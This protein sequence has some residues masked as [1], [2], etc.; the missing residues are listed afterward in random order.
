MPHDTKEWLALQR[1]VHGEFARRLAAI[2]DWDGPTPDTEWNV[3]D[4]VTHVIDEQREVPALLDGQTAEQAR[5]GF[6][7]L[8][9]DLKAEWALYS[10]AA[11]AA[12]HS[13]AEDAP[14]HLSW[15]TVPASEFLRE[16]VSDVTIHTWDLA[17]AIG[18]DEH[19]DT[20]LIEA[21]WTVFEPQA[22]T[23]AASGLYAPSGSDSG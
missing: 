20:E 5:A 17:R 22:D 11:I 8:R 3:R 4:L 13:V 15:D 1:R 9:D 14:V 16:T 21:V 7:P 10:F 18:A 12:W 2:T 23:L 19:L 6:E